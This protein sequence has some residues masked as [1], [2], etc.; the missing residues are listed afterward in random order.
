[1]NKVA[2]LSKY[3]LYVKKKA[4]QQTPENINLYLVRIHLL[5]KYKLQYPQ[6]KFTLKKFAQ[7]ND[8]I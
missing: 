1:M 7:K 4:F 2:Q 3:W 5:N 8:K 6:E